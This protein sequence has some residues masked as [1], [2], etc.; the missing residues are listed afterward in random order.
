MK[1]NLSSQGSSNRWYLFVFG[2]HSVMNL[3]Q[4]MVDIPSEMHIEN[5][6]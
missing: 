5:I 3:G 4:E 6:I 1:K 2:V